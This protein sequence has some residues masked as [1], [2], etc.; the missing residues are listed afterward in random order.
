MNNGLITVGTSRTIKDYIL[1]VK[2]IAVE[3]NIENEQ[4][5]LSEK[6]LQIGL[7]ERDFISVV[8]KS[9]IVLDFGKEIQGGVR[10]LTYRGDSCLVRL[11]FGESLSETYSELKQKFT[12]FTATNDHSPRDFT[13][14]LMVLSDVELANTGFRFL[15][16]DFPECTNIKIKSVLGVFEH[17]PI[18]RLGGFTCSDPLLN[19]IY[20]TAAYTVE[21]CMQHMLWDGI[22]RD[23]LVWV[24]DMHPEVLAIMSLYGYDECVETSLSFAQNTV[25][26]NGFMNGKPSYSLW[27]ICILSDYYL[28]NGNLDYIKANKEQLLAVLHVFETL[29]D[30]DGKL[31]LEDYFLDWSSKEHEE[32]IAGIYALCSYAMRKAKILLQALDLD[33]KICDN[34]LQ[35]IDKSLPSGGLKQVAALKVLGGHMPAENALPELLIGGAKGLSA[36][37]SFYIFSAIAETGKISAAVEIMKEYYGGMLSRGATT[38]WEDFDVDWLID[39]G[40]IDE[41]PPPG[42]KD[43]HGDFGNYCYKGFRHSLCH[44]WSAGPVPFITRY[45]LG[46]KELEA[47]CKM[48]QIRPNL[49]GLEYVYGTFPTP[50]GTVEVMCRNENGEMVTKIKS[51]KEIVVLR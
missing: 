33:T 22:K 13:T 17:R 23:R 9:A 26:E 31:H 4:S 25:P 16:I 10:I 1:P 51:P 48:L 45:I 44:G 43:I 2:I 18:V 15:R 8:G 47:G 49:S 24:G 34:I 41:L 29:V 27:W 39:S 6:F 19:Q 36:F 20:E 32:K 14:E 38:F 46:I 37:M 40:R 28:H 11:R 12:D 21:L 35:R 30:D 3:G 50:Y 7:H 42:V 5:L